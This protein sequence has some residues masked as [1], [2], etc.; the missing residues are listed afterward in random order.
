MIDPA[1]HFKLPLEFYQEFSKRVMATK[2][3]W[4]ESWTFTLKSALSASLVNLHIRQRQHE[5][6][7][8]WKQTAWFH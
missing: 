6:A 1:G 7:F 5:L 4:A 3:C 2:Q 8:Y